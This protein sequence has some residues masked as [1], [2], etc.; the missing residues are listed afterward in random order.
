MRILFFMLIAGA[1]VALEELP[2]EFQTVSV[3]PAGVELLCTSTN[4]GFAKESV[5]WTLPDVIRIE[6][7]RASD[8]S[9]WEVVSFVTGVAFTN[10]TPLMYRFGEG[11]YRPR[12][13]GEKWTLSSTRSGR[14]SRTGIYTNTIGETNIVSVGKTRAELLT[15][16]KPNRE[17]LKKQAKERKPKKNAELSKATREAAAPA[18]TNRMKR[19][20]CVMT[21]RLPNGTIEQTWR[22]GVVSTN[23]VKVLHTAKI[24]KESVR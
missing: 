15:P 3:G 2:K 10:E 4:G 11:M 14:I 22:N 21:R 19:A 20:E 8:T 6:R 16:A 12:S 17:E 13:V 23:E 24:R 1:A 9:I 5:P 18:V 7:V